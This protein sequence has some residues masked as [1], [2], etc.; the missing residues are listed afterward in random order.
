MV[1]FD[2]KRLKEG[3][4]GYTYDEFQIIIDDNN[5]TDKIKEKIDGYDKEEN[6]VYDTYLG[7]LLRKQFHND[8]SKGVYD[9]YLDNYKNFNKKQEHIKPT[10]YSDEQ[11]K[12]FKN[13]YNYKLLSSN[14]FDYVRKYDYEEI[15]KLNL[16]DDDNKKIYLDLP[17]LLSKTDGKV[18]NNVLKVEKEENISDKSINI[19][20]KEFCC[21]YSMLNIQNIPVLFGGSLEEANKERERDSALHDEIKEDDYGI[22]EYNYPYYKYMMG[23]DRIYDS[24]YLNYNKTRNI[25]SINL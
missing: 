13:K 4:A 12:L 7:D 1:I 19:E 5:L 15:D 22:S 18:L 23:N 10:I 6:L 21:D 16:V 17:G 2:K 14:E 8:T 20:G 24:L 3:L 25:G 9:N 11:M